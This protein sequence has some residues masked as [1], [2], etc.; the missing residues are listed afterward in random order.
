MT[1]VKGDLAK[2]TYVAETP[3]TKFRIQPTKRRVDDLQ[4]GAHLHRD[5]RPAVVSES[6][7]I[8]SKSTGYPLC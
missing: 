1:Y 2:Y 6:T 7:S 4:L 3:N 8:S 5:R